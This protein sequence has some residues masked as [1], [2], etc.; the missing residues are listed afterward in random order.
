M[1]GYVEVLQKIIDK[2][3]RN[4]DELYFF[5]T[6]GNKYYSVRFDDASGINSKKYL[7]QNIEDFLLLFIVQ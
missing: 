1:T 4:I 6:L 7:L 2:I 5:L 3:S